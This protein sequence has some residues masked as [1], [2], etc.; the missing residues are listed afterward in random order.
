M[1]VCHTWCSPLPH[2]FPIK[3]FTSGFSVAQVLTLDFNLGTL[4]SQIA[5]ANKELPAAVPVDCCRRRL[6]L[7]FTSTLTATGTEQDGEGARQE[8]GGPYEEWGSRISAGQ[9]GLGVE[10]VLCTGGVYGVRPA[11]RGQGKELYFSV[12]YG[13]Q[14]VINHIVRSLEEIELV[15]NGGSNRT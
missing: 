12:I 4:T 7:L 11:V 5:N 13:V 2:P 8:L 6:S 15:V 9:K 3:T 14:E 1:W 10:P